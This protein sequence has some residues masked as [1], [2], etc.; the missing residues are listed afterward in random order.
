MLCLFFGLWLL[1][2]LQSSFLHVTY[3]LVWDFSKDILCKLLTVYKFFWGTFIHLIFAHF[4]KLADIAA[5]FLSIPIYK[6]ILVTI[7]QLHSA[8]IAIT[9]AHNDDTQRELSTCD[10]HID[11]FSEVMDVSVC[12]N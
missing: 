12:Q 4:D 2:W 9:N 7:E 1:I 8:E 11:G 6:V 10:D 5:R 3:Q